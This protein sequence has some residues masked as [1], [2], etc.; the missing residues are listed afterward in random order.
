[1]RSLFAKGCCGEPKVALPRNGKLLTMRGKMTSKRFD[2]MS[3]TLIDLAVRFHGEVDADAL[4]VVLP[5][6][7]D[8]D[9]LRSRCHGIKVIIAVE[10]EAL[11]APCKEAGLEC[12]LLEMAEVPDRKSTRLNSSHT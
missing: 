9:D 1:M 11:I 3:R 10:S 12:L 5:G 2:E 6:P 8:W 4:L 7:T